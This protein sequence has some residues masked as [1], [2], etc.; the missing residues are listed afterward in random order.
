MPLL[1]T[2]VWLD[3]AA[4]IADESDLAS[5]FHTVLHS[6]CTAVDA[7]GMLLQRRT[8]GWLRVASRV[9]DARA[10]SWRPGISGI[11]AQQGP[12]LRVDAPRDP[13]TA[14]MLTSGLSSPVMLVLGGE[15]HASRESLG[16]SQALAF[17]L[18]AVLERDAMRQLQ[19]SLR[20]AYRATR[21]LRPGL[22]VEAI[23]DRIVKASVHALGASRVSLALIDTSGR[24]TLA[25]MHGLP[26]WLRREPISREHGVIGR[27]LKQRRPI[28][29]T[30]GG[31]E[32][33]RAA[34]DRYRTA[35]FLVTPILAGSEAIGVLC[36]T[37]KHDYSAF[38]DHDCA[39]LRVLA[40]GAAGPLIAARTAAERDRVVEAAAIDPLTK[41]FN[42]QHADLRMQQELERTKRE[43]TTAALL[44]ADVDDFKR[45][46]DTA[47]HQGGDRVLTCVGDIIRSAVRAIDVSARYGG[48]EFI[49]LM[50]NSDMESAHT[51]AKRIKALAEQHCGCNTAG[52]QATISIG[53]AISAA[54]DDAGALFERADKALYVAKAGGKNQIAID[55]VAANEAPAPRRLPYVLIADAHPERLPHYRHW[56]EPFQTGLLVARNNADAL[57]IIERFG[58][59]LMLIVDLTASPLFSEELLERV[60]GGHTRVLAWSHDLGHAVLGPSDTIVHLAPDTSIVSA[61]HV[62]R[63]LLE[64]HAPP[65]EPAGHD[66]AVDVNIDMLAEQIRGMVGPASIAI[67]RPTADLTHFRAAS[68]WY[69]GA[70]PSTTTYDL[71][72]IFGRARRSR[73]AVISGGVTV[74]GDGVTD[75]PPPSGTPGMVAIP[76]RRSGEIRA[77]A[78]IYDNSGLV[79]RQSAIDAIS[80]IA[81][82]TARRES[83]PEEP[84]A[85]KTE[86]RNSVAETPLALLER[87]SG[88]VVAMREL[89]RARREQSQLSVVLFELAQRSRVGPSIPPGDTLEPVVDTFVK[90]VRQSDLP[91]RWAANELLLILPGLTASEARSVAERVRAAMEA[92]ARHAI[93][94]AGGV[95]EA[96]PAVRQFDDIVK[97]ARE[98]VAIAV[99]RGHNR[100]H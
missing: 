79:I 8:N 53:I 30:N 16:A 39:M 60:R 81:M 57:S 68:T 80:T 63:H 93:A 47:G 91:I 19:R 48:D 41:L 33:T 82:G 40:A 49:V 14:V 10:T 17:A 100:V 9:P 34:L 18:A 76:V 52:R 99:D 75:L 92:G 6:I 43:N 83:P 23:A 95:A 11:G 56:T 87:K 97:R 35:S 55:G 28:V 4:A 5:A 78:C 44:I 62:A 25:A 32:R 54:G 66:P 31:A 67:Y 73:D 46:N 13:A 12:L 89:A 2:S 38:D 29:S 71:R 15:W 22:S 98:R 7:Q 26:Q 51:C 45:I 65:R 3:A 58:A 61:R 24:L 64:G 70:P 84:A 21:H 27:V 36:A 42:R 50:P 94:V 88:E 1:P 37:D 20:I 69:A 90:A 59:P 72:A 86:E 74:V 96:D 85:E 77:I